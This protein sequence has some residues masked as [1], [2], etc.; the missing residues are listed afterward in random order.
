MG[1]NAGNNTGGRRRRYEEQV[2]FPDVV[3]LDGALESGVDLESFSLRKD[4]ERGGGGDVA[5]SLYRKCQRPNQSRRHGERGRTLNGARIR[6]CVG[7][8]G[9]STAA[10][11]S[12]RCRLDCADGI[13]QL[14]V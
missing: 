14:G 6:E 3:G 12:M 10:A 7:L 8:V 1:D 2:Q 13:A 9:F 5:D 11:L 4:R